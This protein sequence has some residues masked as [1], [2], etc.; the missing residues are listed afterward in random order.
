[1]KRRSFKIPEQPG[2]TF[3]WIDYGSVTPAP[4]TS[5]FQPCWSC[6]GYRVSP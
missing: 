3:L 5:L 2:F 4:Q 1:M 6:E